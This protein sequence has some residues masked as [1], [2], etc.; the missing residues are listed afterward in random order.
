MQV[1]FISSGMSVIRAIGHLNAD[2]AVDFEHRLLAAIAG[3]PTLQ[4]VIDLSGVVDIDR[5]G[6]MA[7]VAALRMARCSNRRLLFCP[8][9]TSLQMVFELTQLDQV[10]EFVDSA[11]VAVPVAA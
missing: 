11:P 4:I 2:S 7:L 6:L 8:V 10:C 5:S 1:S 3:D 9:P